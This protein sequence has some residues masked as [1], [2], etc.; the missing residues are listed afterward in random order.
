MGRQYWS[1][2]VWTLPDHL[3]QLKTGQGGKGF[4]QSHLWCQDD[5][6]RLRDRIELYTS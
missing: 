1:G 4:L 2:H 6:L 3:G 5:H